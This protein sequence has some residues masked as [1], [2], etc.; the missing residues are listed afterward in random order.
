MQFC[1]DDKKRR[2]N[3]SFLRMH[4]CIASITSIHLSEL[5]TTRSHCRVCW[6]QF[7]DSTAWGIF[8][9]HGTRKSG[10][11][12]CG[13]RW[14][15]SEMTAEAFFDKDCLVYT[16]SPPTCDR[17][18][19]LRL[20]QHAAVEWECQ[21]QLKYQQ[22]RYERFEECKIYFPPVYPVPLPAMECVFTIA[23]IFNARN[24]IRD[25]DFV[26]TS[27][28]CEDVFVVLNINDTDCVQKWLLA[29]ECRNFLAALLPHLLR[30]G[31]GQSGSR[32]Q[33]RN[34]GKTDNACTDSMLFKPETAAFSKPPV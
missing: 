6:L 7:G 31:I 26:F 21:R 15:R 8:C 1:A 2:N 14:T 12:L 34:A 9:Q 22:H 29:I 23:C 5:I 19:I 24:A 4:P 25:Q 32:R 33:F 16:C 3:I 10:C 18:E 17:A 13:D 27:N 30:P 20:V 28:V 11:R